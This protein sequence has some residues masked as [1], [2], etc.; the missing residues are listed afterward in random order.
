MP[1]LGRIGSTKLVLPKWH[2]YGILNRVIRVRPWFWL[3]LID[4]EETSKGIKTSTF[5][6]FTWNST[7]GYSCS[8]V[9]CTYSRI[10]ELLSLAK[11]FELS[12]AFLLILLQLLR[13]CTV[14]ANQ[15][16]HSHLTDL[17]IQNSKWLIWSQQRRRF[18]FVIN[19][20]Y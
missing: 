18:V 13:I 8:S 14:V 10:L 16:C 12:I 1:Y 4:N 19:F 11:N 6:Y 20:W 2:K 3:T 9:M 7:I 15:D 5:S 17:Q